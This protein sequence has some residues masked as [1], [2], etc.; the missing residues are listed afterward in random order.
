MLTEAEA[1]TRLERLV[2]H[3]TP[4]T[5]GG[6]EV[7]AL[8]LEAARVD[9]LGVLREGA[10]VEWSPE[11]AYADGA[12]V[13]PTAK[14]GL[15]YRVSVAGTSGAGEPAWTPS[16][17]VTDGSVTWE[18]DTAMPAAW[19]PTFDLAAAAAEGWRMKAALVSDRFRFA[20]DG[21]SYDRDQVFAHC[22]RMAELYEQ[23]VK[24]G[25]L[26]VGTPAGGTGTGYS[27]IPLTRST[28]ATLD[29]ERMISLEQWSGSGPIPRVN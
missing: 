7:L 28:R 9:A 12:T 11:I 10:G 26:I 27:S 6:A 19:A 16:G 5:L 8:L 14:N 13:V 21:D 23:K 24:A 20:D 3:A 4:P 1:R 25:S 18:I 15:R 17:T 2:A 29:E 22:V